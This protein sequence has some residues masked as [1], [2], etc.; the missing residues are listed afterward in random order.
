L[1][2]GDIITISPEIYSNLHS[3]FLKKL[4]RNQILTNF[5]PYMEVNYYI[6]S[7]VLVKK[8]HFN[9]IS[10]PFLVPTRAIFHQF[11]K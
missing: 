2:V 10:Y 8:P 4:I 1:L 5:P 7:I 11:A 6:G 9:E 3:E